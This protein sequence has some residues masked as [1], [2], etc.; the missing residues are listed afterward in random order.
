MGRDMSK[1]KLWLTTSSAA[2]P[3]PIRRWASQAAAYE[4]VTGTRAQWRAGLSAVSRIT[5]WVDER[6]GHGWRTFEALD[7]AAETRGEA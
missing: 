4:Y 7:F 5:V 2:D 3:F 6:D 1:R